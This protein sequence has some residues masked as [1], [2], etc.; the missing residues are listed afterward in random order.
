MYVPISD[1]VKTPPVKSALAGRYSQRIP[2]PWSK[3]MYQYVKQHQ[4]LQMEERFELSYGNQPFSIAI[5][6]QY[7]AAPGPAVVPLQRWRDGDCPGVMSMAGS[8]PKRKAD[9]LATAAIFGV[10]SVFGIVSVSG[11]YDLDLEKGYPPW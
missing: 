9:P 11:F 7:T 3:G 4:A 5:L 10:L 6:Y 8:W 1:F 2:T